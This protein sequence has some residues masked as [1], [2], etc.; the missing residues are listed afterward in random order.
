ME[1]EGRPEVRPGLHSLTSSLSSCRRRGSLILQ[2]SY[3]CGSRS[4]SF[5]EA[6]TGCCFE[7]FV[8]PCVF[9][10]LA[11]VMSAATWRSESLWTVSVRAALSHPL[12]K[13]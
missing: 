12:H 10:F 7:T 4:T 9:T 5:S 13:H 3:T 6:L 11:A 2:S 1:D 8:V